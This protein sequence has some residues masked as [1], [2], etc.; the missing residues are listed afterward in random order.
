[1]GQGRKSRR[2]R[3]ATR[4]SEYASD[5][6]VVATSSDGLLDK[7]IRGNPQGGRERT[8]AEA[9]HRTVDTSC[10]YLLDRSWLPRKGVYN[11]LGATQMASEY[12]DT[13]ETIRSNTVS[14]HGH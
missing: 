8:A 12:V 10:H 5:C 1:M 9:A 2:E 11:S 4:R 6:V 14:D 3:Y 13:G 7:A